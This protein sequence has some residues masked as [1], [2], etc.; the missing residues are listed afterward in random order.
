METSAEYLHRLAIAPFLGEFCSELTEYRFLQHHLAKTQSQLRITLLFCSVFYLAFALT[1]IAVLGQGH[2]AFVLFVGRLSVAV[3]A[4]AGTWLTYRHP[5][6]IAVTWL[7]ATLVEVAGMSVFMLVVVYRPGELHWHAMSMAIML[8]VVYIYIP[9]RLV[10]S[11]AVA[12]PSTAAFIVLALKV[13]HLNQP[14]I[15][16]MTM[17]LLLAN[18]F[19]AVAAHRYHHLWR[20]EFRAQTILKS[21]SVHDQL[22]GCFN[23]RYLHESL[24]AG[25]IARARRSSLCMAVIL[26]DLDHFKLVNDTYGHCGG[27]AVLRT[28]SQLLKKM[29]REHLDTV[30]RYGGEEFLIILPET[31]L[32]GGVLL[33]ERLRVA[34]AA[35]ASHEGDRV[36]AAT[37]SFGVAAVDF[38]RN[39]NTIT[40]NTLITSAD[41]LLYDAKKNGRNRVTSLQLF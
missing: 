36:I 20:E 38:A 5:Q 33:A 29:T 15:F 35:A 11:L 32:C 4:A 23:R 41:E 18:T 12:L 9:N 25:E 27:D 2:A 21:V 1:D 28:F 19:G 7:A 17:L 24:L 13:G 8:I 22:T 30:V 37:A 10:Y 34:F 16:T 3:A 39:K 6:S 40:L 26:C 31:D 14:D